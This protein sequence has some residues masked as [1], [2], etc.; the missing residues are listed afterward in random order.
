MSNEATERQRKRQRAVALLRRAAAQVELGVGRAKHGVKRR[1]GWIDPVE[2]LP[3]RGFGTRSRVRLVG[4]VV[5]AKGLGAP[6]PEDRPWQNFKRMVH[7]LNSAEIP[8]VRVSLQF[9][10]VRAETVTD[11]EG[12]FEFELLS[13]DGAFPSPTAAAGGWHEAALCLESEVSP[14]QGR[15][16]ARAAIMIPDDEAELAIVSDVDDTVIQTHVTNFS[17]MVRV[18][19]LGNALT[20]LPFEGTTDLYCALA[21]GPRG[22]ARNPVF[23]VSKSPWNLYDLLVDFLD[24]HRVP[25]GPLL[26]RDWGIHAQASLD[27]KQ[28][29]IE[30]LLALY[31]ALRFVLIGDSGERD[32][33]IYLDIV[34][35]H[36]GRVAA[37]YIRAVHTDGK[38]HAEL[39][40]VA[41]RAR[42]AGVELLLLK[43]AHEA[44]AHARAHGL[45]AM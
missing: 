43:H 45:A 13:E 17:K 5:E 35:R 10:E 6:A 15:V 21:A 44:L 3:Y 32:P 11:H 22:N 14:G 8:G 42:A 20:R 18:T 16:E 29:R 9:G 19:M 26:L 37:V 41:A 27:F 36:P 2:I 23:Y 34:E 12:Y 40:A 25:P 28:R 33:E 7:R 39:E 24:R 30:Q 31:P 38:R 1:F 4:R